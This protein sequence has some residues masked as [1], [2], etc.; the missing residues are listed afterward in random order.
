M[1][2]IKHFLVDDSA[3]AEVTSTVI[4]IAA[5]GLLLAAGLYVWYG[6]LNNFFSTAGANAQAAATQMKWVGN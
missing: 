3:T 2:R 6:Y 5:V 1:Q 4:M